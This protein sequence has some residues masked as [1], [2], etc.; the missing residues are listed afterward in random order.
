MRD[1]VAER[2]KSNFLTTSERAVKDK[3]IEALKS[4]V[5][6][7]MV[8]FTEELGAAQEDLGIYL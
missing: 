7:E 8:K 1:S 3:D 2:F 5:E 4:Q 6:H